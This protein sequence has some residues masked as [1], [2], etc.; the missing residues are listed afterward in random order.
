[1]KNNMNINRACRYYLSKD[2]DFILNLLLFTLISL[3][4]FFTI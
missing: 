2:K 3:G 1:M 4:F